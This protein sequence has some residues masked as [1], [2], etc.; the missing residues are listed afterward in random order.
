MTF[1]P[2]T[3]SA[4]HALIIVVCLLPATVAAAEPLR[5]HIDPD[6]FGASEQDVRR[7]LESAGRELCRH[8]PD[9]E[10]EPILVTRGRQGPITLFE[11]NEQRQIVVR[12]DTEGTYWSQYSYQW[13]HELCH[14][15]CRYRA[16]GQDNKWFEETLCELASLYVLRRMSESWANEPPYPNWRDYRH[17]LRK[18]ADDVIA[19][20]EQI[21]LPELAAYYARHAGTLR[22]TPTDRDR[23]GAIAAA[24]LPLFEESP[25]HWEAV[26]WLNAEPAPP[27][28]S[29]AEYLRRWRQAVPE[30]HQ[31]W[32]ERIAATFGVAIAV[33]GGD[34]P[35]R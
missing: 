23:N 33:D 11:R 14:I 35:R 7:L 5:L 26:H 28:L 13:S 27:G 17:A 16:D 6:G 20:R 31:P 22:R 25:E 29:F 10:L 24:L 1:P 21:P 4:R 34:Q 19:S 30:R 2:P 3:P 15:L 32:V 8:F 12:L 9:C 18:Y